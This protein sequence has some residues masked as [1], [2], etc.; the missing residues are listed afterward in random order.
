MK[1][2]PIALTTFLTIIQTE[3]APTAGFPGRYV[4]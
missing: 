1:L 4:L 2:Q 3:K